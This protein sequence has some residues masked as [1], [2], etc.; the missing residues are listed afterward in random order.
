VWWLTPAIP[1]GGDKRIPVVGSQGKKKLVK[2]YLKNKLG[3][4][5]SLVIPALQDAK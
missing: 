2:S 4:W 3:M 1:G 5:Y